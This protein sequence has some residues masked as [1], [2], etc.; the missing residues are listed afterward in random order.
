MITTETKKGV[1]SEHRT[2]ATDT[3]SP[4][5]QIA[6]L[7]TRIQELTGH[8]KTHPKDNH[9]RRGLL[10]MVGKRK[11]LLKYL[12]DTDGEAYLELI[13]RLGLRR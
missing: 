4:Q 8:L 11:K 10:Q 7:T 6:M 12:R 2:H 1:I 3:G 5:V 13:A 9:S